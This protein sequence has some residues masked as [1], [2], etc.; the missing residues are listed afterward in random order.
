MPPISCKAMLLSSLGG[1]QM[2]TDSANAVIP[3]HIA[4][5]LDGNGRWAKKRGLPRNMGHRQG[6]K[7]LE[8]IIHRCK[9]LGVKYLTLYVFS[10]ENWSRPADEVT[11]IMDL[12][13]RHLK[14]AEKYTAENIRL[15]VLGD[16]DRL[17]EDIQKQI[18]D[19]EK[20]SENNDAITVSFALNYG[21][22]QEILHAA[23]LA[24]ENAA[25]EGREPCSITENDIESCLY[26]AGFPDP[27]III[28]PSGEKRLSNFLLWQC[29]YSEF[30]F[31]DILWPDFTP[32][33]LDNAIAEFAR[34][35]RRFGGL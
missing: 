30:I 11:G 19:I 28:R 33:D 15:K 4:I 16:I 29:A 13:R 7:A 1:T 25:K 10:T 31:M 32:D 17:D 3:A 5:I 27:D 35:S 18:A 34:R 26:T 24:A 6:A 21:G 9:E 2:Q 8:P 14:N 20:I 22:R 23:R 12:L